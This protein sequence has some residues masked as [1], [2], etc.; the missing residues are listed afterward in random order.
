MKLLITCGHNSSA[1]GLTNS[2]KIIAGYEEERLTRVKSDSHWPNNAINKILEQHLFEP[3]EENVM[4]ISHWNDGFD[5]INNN[6]NPKHID[7]NDIDRL[8]D[9]PWNFRIQTL[10]PGFTHHD[11][12]AYSVKSFYDKH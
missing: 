11:A 5:I 10:A 1:I 7:L 2:G 4:Y 8:C 6:P 3:D 12:H 9:N